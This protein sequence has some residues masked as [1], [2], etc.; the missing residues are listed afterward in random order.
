MTYLP[1][2]KSVNKIILKY[3]E[4]LY[5]DEQ[6]KMVSTPKP[7]ILL[8]S[9]RKL[10]RANIYPTKR[11]LGFYKCEGKRCEAYIN[12]NQKWT[13]TSTVTGE[14]CTIN[15]RFDCKEKHFF[16]SSF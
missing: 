6:F 7:I 3:L 15:Y 8:R 14:A 10:V 4:F 1:K 11:T 12:I 13:F 16:L 5:M 9:A 2:L